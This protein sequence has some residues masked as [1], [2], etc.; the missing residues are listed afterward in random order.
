MFKN[1]IQKRKLKKYWKK[2]GDE[3]STRTVFNYLY[4]HKEL[5][6][7]E[8]YKDMYDYHRNILIGHHRIT[9]AHYHF[10]DT[11]IGGFVDKFAELRAKIAPDRIDEPASYVKKLYFLWK[12]CPKLFKIDDD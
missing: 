8:I 11:I 9:M 5:L 1:L 7:D 12:A 2:Y 10:D 3:N 4:S 6:S